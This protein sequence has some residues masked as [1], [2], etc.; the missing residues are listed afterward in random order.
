MNGAELLEISSAARLLVRIGLHTGET[1]RDGKE[2]FGKSLMVAARVAAEARGGEVLASG[3]V[4]E[5]AEAAD[6][7]PPARFEAPREIPLRGLAGSHRVYNVEV[8]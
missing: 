6:C 2:I 4:K 7:S 3:T 5:F 1:I 8:A